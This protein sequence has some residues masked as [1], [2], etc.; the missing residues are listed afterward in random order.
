MNTAKAP[1][2]REN[3]RY[4]TIARKRNNPAKFNNVA[5]MR[6][7]LNAYKVL[8]NAGYDQHALRT[9]ANQFE[10]STEFAMKEITDMS[11][12]MYRMKE[13]E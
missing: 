7:Q 11:N 8:H 6:R 1:I 3:R 10:N 5:E 4:E 13:E 2:E 9:L 12:E